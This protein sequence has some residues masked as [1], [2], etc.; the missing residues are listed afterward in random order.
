M[1]TKRKEKEI[2]KKNN[3]KIQ[4]RCAIGFLS[5]SPKKSTKKQR[6][7]AGPKEVLG[8]CGVSF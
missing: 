4:R 1:P 6:L 8:H 7:N 3:R 2:S 5:C